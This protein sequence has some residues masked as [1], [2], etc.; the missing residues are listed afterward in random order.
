M[1]DFTKFF[2]QIMF[3][4]VV[5]IKIIMECRPSHLSTRPCNILCKLPYIVSRR[6]IVC[7]YNNLSTLV[8]GH[9]HAKFLAVFPNHLGEVT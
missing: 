9:S 7:N 2:T 4:Y 3:H 6:I 8:S 5:Y 1:S